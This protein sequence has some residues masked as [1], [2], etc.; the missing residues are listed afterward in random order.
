MCAAFIQNGKYIKYAPL[1]LAGFILYGTVSPWNIINSSWKNQYE[2]LS[3]ILTKYDLLKDDKI[4]NTSDLKEKIKTDDAI[5]LYDSWI[6]LEKKSHKQA[7]AYVDGK[8]FS[9]TFTQILL[10]LY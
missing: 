7:P 1:V 5:I 9:E 10:T 8:D 4:I 3:K 6:Y 2:R